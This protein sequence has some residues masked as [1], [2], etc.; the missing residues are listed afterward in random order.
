M[1]NKILSI[2]RR[3]NAGSIITQT[4]DSTSRH[5]IDQHNELYLDNK[6]NNYYFFS[7]VVDNENCV[8]ING[9]EK[10]I[11]ESNLYDNIEKPSPSESY[12]ILLWKVESLDD[13]L[14]P[15]IIEIEENEF[16]FKKY[17]FYYTEAE[18]NECSNWLDETF[19]GENISVSKL[20]KHL[21]SIENTNTYNFLT[22]LLI[23]LPY[24]ELDFEKAE[25][26]DFNNYIIDDINAMRTNKNEVEYLNKKLTSLL[27]KYDDEKVC[28]LLIDELMENDND[29]I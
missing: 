6:R 24:I 8:D 9:I 13:N 2:I 19:S 11:S 1:N 28:K 26:K 21:P 4:D 29:R 23:K 22:R 5:S 20:L 3:I 15:I 27:T 16:V 14:F 7:D 17:V 10:A 18:L 25:L 12:L